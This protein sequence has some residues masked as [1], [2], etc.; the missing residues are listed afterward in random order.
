MDFSQIIRNPHLEGDSFFYEGGDTGVL[1]FH[2]FTA[3]TAEVRLLADCL[4]ASGLTIS[5]PL[6]PGHGTH[7]DDL[8]RTK[9]QEWIA[10]GENAL[11]VLSER[12][13]QVFV[14]GE[15][16]GALV[17]IMLAAKHP[18]IA[19]VILFAPALK[20]KNLWLS[21]FLSLFVKQLVKK[22]AND[23]LAWKGYNVYPMRGNA[24]MLKLQQKARRNLKHISQPLLVVTGALDHTIAPECANI[25][26]QNV[27]S[28]MKY[29]IDMLEFGHCV[30]L[31]KEI[32]QVCKIT[33]GFITDLKV[34]I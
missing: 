23:K 12:T 5:A 1:M 7:P 13:R 21:P 3:T 30:M 31:D 16:M 24:Q 14:C 32:D 9:W 34:S 11:D 33:Q 19:G 17:A 28:K 2:G 26:I 10:C 25:I 20:V 22:S 29:H 6:L 15:S 18:S 8:N 4:H 27:S